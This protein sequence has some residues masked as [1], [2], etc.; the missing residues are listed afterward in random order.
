MLLPAEAATWPIE[1]RGIVLLHELAHA[2][3]WDCLT[4]AIARVVCVRQYQP[5]SKT[6]REAVAKEADLAF[7]QAFALCPYIPVALT[8]PCWSPRL[9]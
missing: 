9:L 1:R 4:Q 2:K 5:R 6:E 7:K 8:M 3:R